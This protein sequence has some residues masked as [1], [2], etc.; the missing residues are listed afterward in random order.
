MLKYRIK[1]GEQNRNENDS[2]DIYYETYDI[3]ELP[4]LS[5]DKAE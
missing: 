3:H 5:D 2:F 4:A 1:K